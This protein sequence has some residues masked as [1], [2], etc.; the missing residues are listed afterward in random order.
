M[1]IYYVFHRQLQEI[2]ANEA[3]EEKKALEQKQRELQERREK[4]DQR[5]RALAQAAV[6]VITEILHY[7]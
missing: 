5:K 6:E 4:L 7:Y 3:E 1:N 2:K